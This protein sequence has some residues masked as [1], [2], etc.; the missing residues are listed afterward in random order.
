[1]T[2]A[3]PPKVRKS[4]GQQSLQRRTEYGKSIPRPNQPQ[5]SSKKSQ[6]T[7]LEKAREEGRAT[8]EL[9]LIET[10]EREIVQGRVDVS[11]DS[12]GLFPFSLS[13]THAQAVSKKQRIYF[14]R[15]S[16]FL[17]SFLITFKAF[18][19]LGKGC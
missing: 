7:F 19:D 17:S 16:F 2:T 14:R 15:L 11:W 9:E 13:L 8:G 6:L 4:T 3:T 1:M 5:R 12:I 18:V 10:I